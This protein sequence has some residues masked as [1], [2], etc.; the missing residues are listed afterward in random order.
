MEQTYT[1]MN[2][3]VTTSLVYAKIVNESKRKAVDLIPAL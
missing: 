3:R 2:K 1:P